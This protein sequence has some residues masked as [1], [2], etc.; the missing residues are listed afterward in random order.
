M[1]G[2]R[3][4]WWRRVACLMTPACGTPNDNDH[5]P[6][7]AGAT[8]RADFA[9]SQSC[10][11]RLCSRTSLPAQLGW[12]GGQGPAFADPATIDPPPPH[13]C[14]SFVEPQVASRTLTSTRIQQCSMHVW[15]RPTL[16]WKMRVNS[17][18]P[19]EDARMC[20]LLSAPG[21]ALGTRV[22]ASAGLRRA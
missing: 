6:Q 12:L 7:P 8:G 22:C 5:P 20:W 19:V 15:G 14:P 2:G 21:A 16:F 1:C 13:P 10:R 11:S 4:G 9:G 18:A 17:R 3:G